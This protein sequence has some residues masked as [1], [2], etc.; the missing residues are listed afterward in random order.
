[1]SNVNELIVVFEHFRRQFVSGEEV[2]VLAL[3]L[4]SSYLHLLP[5]YELNVQAIKVRDYSGTA[6]CVLP[7]DMK[8]LQQDIENRLI[9]CDKLWS[10]FDSH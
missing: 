9:S 8:L 6:G 5:P 2:E 7:A 3:P 1:M 4:P 10:R